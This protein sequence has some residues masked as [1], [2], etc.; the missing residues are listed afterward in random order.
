MDQDTQKADPTSSSERLKEDTQVGQC[1]G[2]WSF[3]EE[4][5]RKDQSLKRP[6]CHTKEAPAVLE[7]AEIISSSRCVPGHLQVLSVYHRF[8]PSQLY[9]Q[10]GHS[11]D[12]RDLWD[13]SEGH[14]EGPGPWVGRGAASCGWGASQRKSSGDPREAASAGGTGQFLPTNTSQEAA[15]FR[16]TSLS[17]EE[18]T[19]GRTQGP[20][21]GR[22]GN[23]GLRAASPELQ[24]DLHRVGSTGQTEVLLGH[25]YNLQTNTTEF[26]LQNG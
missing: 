18:A 1:G 26:T 5:K 20:Q 16:S 3:K 23:R 15:G 9:L 19:T 10:V 11:E 6:R 13:T 7:G 17:A 14:L 25:T 21:Q 12:S 22:W 2:K 4:K 8:W 24:Q